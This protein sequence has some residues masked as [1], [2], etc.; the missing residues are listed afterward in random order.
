MSKTFRSL[1]FLF[2]ISFLTISVSFASDDVKQVASVTK[3]EY[4][5]VQY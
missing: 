4:G 1:I 5:R 2:V 3:K